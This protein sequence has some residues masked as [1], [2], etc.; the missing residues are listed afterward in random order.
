[1]EIAVIGG[2]NIGTLIAAEFAARGH[3]V[4]LRASE[5]QIFSK[6]IDVFDTDDGLI[7]QGTLS[8]ITDD[9][10]VAVDG[11]EMICITYPTFMFRDLGEKLAACIEAG[12]TVCVMPGAAAEFFFG[13]CID[14]GA[15]LLG[16]QRVHCVARLKERGKSVYMLGRKAELQ[17]ASVPARIAQDRASVVAELFEMPVRVLPNYLVETLTPSNPIL[18]TTR[19]CSMF[20]SWEPGIVYPANILFYESWDD[21]SS[22][23]LIACDDELQR[24]CRALERMLDIDLSEV[25]SLKAHYESPDAAAMTAKIAH[26]PAFKGLTSPMRQVAPG[27]WAPD[28]TSRYFRADF[29]YGLKII[30]DFAA[31]AGIGTPHIDHVWEWYPGVSSAREFFEGIPAGIEALKA[32]YHL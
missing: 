15:A 7:L 6:T 29:P 11:A 23:L 2:G 30:K 14:K 9:L 22:E 28:F 26:I 12:Q 20:S 3:S 16:L 24:V 21:A 17:L 10:A 13:A 19:L 1:M 5:P 27:Q 4:R 32:L 31:F 25:L 8:C 18:H